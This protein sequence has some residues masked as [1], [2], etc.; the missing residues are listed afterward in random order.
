MTE[1]MN[2]E[3]NDEM[4]D[5]V[6]G[7]KSDSKWSSVDSRHCPKCNAKLRKKG[8]TIACVNGHYWKN[9]KVKDI[10]YENMAGTDT[11]IFLRK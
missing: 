8:S 1:E 5:E 9:C 6:A 3:L 7:G 11:G 2:V 10:A 4:L